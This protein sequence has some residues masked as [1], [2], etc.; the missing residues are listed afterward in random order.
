MGGGDEQLCGG[1]DALLL[2][3]LVEGFAHRGLEA[4]VKIYGAEINLF[5]YRIEC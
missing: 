5:R 1:A 3:V 4:V 2:D